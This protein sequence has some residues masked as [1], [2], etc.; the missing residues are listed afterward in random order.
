MQELI[1][2]NSKINKLRQRF[3]VQNIETKPFEELGIFF[4]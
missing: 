2:I 4:L 1:Q 3:I